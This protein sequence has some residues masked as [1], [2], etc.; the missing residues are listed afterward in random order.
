VRET[1]YGPH[2]VTLG[3]VPNTNHSSYLSQDYQILWLTPKREFFLDQ[4]V[5]AITPTLTP[6]TLSNPN[7]NSRNAR[8]HPPSRATTQGMP[9]RAKSQGMSC[10]YPLSRATTQGI[11][12]RATTQGMPQQSPSSLLIVQLYGPRR[13]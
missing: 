7:H 6:T 12:F 3:G 4:S 1:Y 11:P 9:L 10:V 2:S 8:V 13:P 5:R